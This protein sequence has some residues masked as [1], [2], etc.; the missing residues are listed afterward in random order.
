MWK[1]PR[2]LL[3]EE[4]TNKCDHSCD[5]ILLSSKKKKKVTHYCRCKNMTNSKTCYEK[6]ILNK[7]VHNLAPFMW[8]FRR[9]SQNNGYLGEEGGFTGKEWMKLAGMM[10][11]L[12]SLGLRLHKLSISWNSWKKKWTFIQFIVCYFY[13]KRKK[14]HQEIWTLIDDKHAQVLG[15]EVHISNI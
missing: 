1:Q 10:V 5:G 6:E 3:S 15:A 12:F 9:N 13:L 14:N 7:G 4:W 2:C 11:I 8:S